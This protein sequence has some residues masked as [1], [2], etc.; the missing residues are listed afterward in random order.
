M[1]Y[2]SRDTTRVLLYC[3]EHE[4]SGALTGLECDLACTI[5][6]RDT[7]TASRPKTVQYKTL[8]LWEFTEF[9]GNR[10]TSTWWKVA[11]DESAVISTWEYDRSR[12]FNTRKE[13]VSYLFN[14][15]Y[16]WAKAMK[17]S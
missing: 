14:Y 9:Y 8:P 1:L 2:L 6:I 13:D 5:T 3:V 11:V 10:Y 4:K 17:E 16:Q 15:H 7:A 12:E